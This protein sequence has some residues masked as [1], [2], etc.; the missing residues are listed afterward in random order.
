M[1]TGPLKPGGT[2]PVIAHTQ[3][4]ARG[5]WRRDPEIVAVFP[6]L[7]ASVQAHAQEIRFRRGDAF[8]L[9]VQVQ[10]DQDPPDQVGID[11]CFAR[12]A[13]KQGYGQ[14]DAYRS[15]L[16]NEAAT[17][18][19]TSAV[20]RDILLGSGG[21]LTV[22]IDSGDTRDHPMVPFVW[23]LEITRRA[24][25]IDVP[26]TVTVVSG[27][28][29]IPATDPQLDAIRVGDLLEIQGTRVRVAEIRPDHFV[30]D[31]DGWTT[32]LFEPWRA[33]RGDSRVVASGPWVA[34]GSTLR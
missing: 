27:Q 8:A 3:I 7:S 34:E 5:V 17:V 26:G 28:K 4:G 1:N 30:T 20:P 24:A 25:E 12:F 15:F 33:W 2:D 22:F 14:T 9:R 32:A 10:D 18:F 29:Q 19:K 16:G 23:S 6:T 13:V 11:G 31:H 21:R